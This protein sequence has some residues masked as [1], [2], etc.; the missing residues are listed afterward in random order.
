M[1][2]YHRTRRNRANDNWEV[3]RQ[4]IDGMWFHIGHVTA[5]HSRH[6][7][8]TT[9]GKCVATAETK[10]DAVRKLIATYEA[11]S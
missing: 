10:R 2:I 6:W 5:V 9:G 3:Q 11:H 4:E 1:T 7:Q 8:A